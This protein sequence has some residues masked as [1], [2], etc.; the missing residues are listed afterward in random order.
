MLL[1]FYITWESLFEFLTRMQLHRADLH[2]YYMIFQPGMIPVLNPDSKVSLC[3]CGQGLLS[4]QAF[5]GFSS[6]AANSCEFIREFKT[7]KVDK[8]SSFSHRGFWCL[9]WC[10]VPCLLVHLFSMARKS[11]FIC[12]KTKWASAFLCLKALSA[13]IPKLVKLHTSQGNHPQRVLVV[14]SEL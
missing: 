10:L 3:N 5:K 2:P 6:S 8:I 12:L 7:F 1:R 4:C 13:Y 11:L 9:H 14:S